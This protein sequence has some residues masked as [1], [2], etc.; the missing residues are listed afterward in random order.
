MSLF[1]NNV[2][3]LKDDT[4]LFKGTSL[5]N[6][7]TIDLSISINLKCQVVSDET[8]WLWHRRLGHVSI[9]LISNLVRKN[10]VRG[11]PQ[12][13]FEKDHL[14]DACQ[15]G[16]RFRES[17]PSKTDVTTS[18]VLDLLYLDLFGPTQIASI[19]EMLYGFVII[20]DFS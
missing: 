17:Q 11:L 20:D 7:Y 15:H 8:C 18:K 3:I 16:K 13:K 4:I 5:N 6:T 10:L 19:C 14:C 2:H 1:N 12:I 9:Y